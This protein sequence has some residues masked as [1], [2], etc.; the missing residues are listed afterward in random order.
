M[1]KFYILTN[2]NGA[3]LHTNNVFYTA[4]VN[5]GT[6][7]L[8]AYKSLKLAQKRALKV[9]G[10]YVLEVEEGQPISSGRMVGIKPSY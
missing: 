5:M 7:H 6:T 2:G 9:G 1:K 8:V 4:V 10:C 3:Y